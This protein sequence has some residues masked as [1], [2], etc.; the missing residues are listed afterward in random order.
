MHNSERGPARCPQDVRRRDGENRGCRIEVEGLM[1][2]SFYR[3]SLAGTGMYEMEGRLR[4]GKRERRGKG[5]E[6]FDLALG[7]V[8]EKGVVLEGLQE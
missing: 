2:A 5:S 8:E 1:M 3:C 7:R 6:A 4:G